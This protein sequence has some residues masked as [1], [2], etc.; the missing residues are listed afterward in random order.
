MVGKRNMIHKTILTLGLLASSLFA[1]NNNKPQSTE[2][3]YTVEDVTKLEDFYYDKDF[4]YKEDYEILY[5]FSK[6]KPIYPFDGS[7]DNRTLK[8][9]R[10]TINITYGPDSR[11][12]ASVY[13]LPG[14]GDLNLLNKPLVVADAFDPGSERGVDQIY[15]SPQYQRLFSLDNKYSPRHEGYDIVFIDFAQGG[16]NIVINAGLE[17]AVM[18]WLES[19]TSARYI[20]GGPSMSGIV[21]RLA[22]LFGQ[23]R[24]KNVKGYVSIDSPHQGA[25]IPYNLQKILAKIF[26]KCGVRTKDVMKQWRKINTPAAWQM[27]YNH[28]ETG[29]GTRVKC[30]VHRGLKR[31]NRV[32]HK[33]NFYG[34]LSDL[35]NY[36]TGYPK[37]AIAYSDF[38]L[39]NGKTWHSGSV[40]SFVIIDEKV[41][42]SG[43]DFMPG[44]SGNWLY[45]SYKKESP[46]FY[47]AWRIGGSKFSGTFIPIYSALDLDESFDIFNSSLDE[48][49]IVKHS[50]FDKVVFMKDPT[51]KF[52]VKGSQAHRYEHIVFDE[53]L[54]QG[55]SESLAY[56]ER[57]N[58]NI[59][60]T[61]ITPL[62][63]N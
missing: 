29:Y 28:I 4:Y 50:P 53:Q 47:K 30:R 20:V 18:E 16:G 37:V 52:N 36:P 15:A 46:S 21:S 39:P 1:A 45:S 60:P 31:W 26:Y 13:I 17:L 62:L 23:N 51:K 55:I 48:E 38:S 10:P 6:N 58:Y 34:F 49:Y 56:I 63:L 24:L 27:L 8:T 14:K 32:A 5:H 35:G 33:E 43:H 41:Y 22:L 44:S 2:H 12:Q 11:Y 59:V 40:G 7:R 57:Q 42:T 25:N 3:W 54:M 61:I 19:Q 9:A